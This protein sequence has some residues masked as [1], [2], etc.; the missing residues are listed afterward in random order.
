MLLGNVMV[1][2]ILK[3][4]GLSQGMLIWASV[5]M[6]SGWAVSRSLCLSVCLSVCLSF[7][8]SEY[9]SISSFCLSVVFARL[10]IV[11]M[12]GKPKICLNLV[13][14]NTEPSKNLT[15]VQLVFPTEIVCSML[16]KLKVTKI[17]F[18]CIREN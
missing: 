5:N 12:C 4:V 6:L 1:V 15:F 3:T 17:N 7:C 2:P 16:F 14:K 10:L 9:L 18:T 8:L 11:G 13:Y